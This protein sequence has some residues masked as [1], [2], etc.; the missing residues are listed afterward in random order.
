MIANNTPW[1]GLE[2]GKVDTRRVAAGARW[3]WFWAVMPRADVALV[4]QLSTL[5]KP[6]PDLPI[7]PAIK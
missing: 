1:S 2:A 3:S 7:N 6:P 5:P 4:L